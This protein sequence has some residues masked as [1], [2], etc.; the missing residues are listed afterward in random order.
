[1]YTMIY[2]Q[3]EKEKKKTLHKCQADTARATQLAKP[4]V[5]SIC[6]EMAGTAYSTGWGFPLLIFCVRTLGNSEGKGEKLKER[7][8]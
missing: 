4:L 5:P 1:M 2:S 7:M 3:Q 8:V 6:T